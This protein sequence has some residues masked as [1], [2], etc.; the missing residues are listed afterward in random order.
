MVTIQYLHAAIQPR[1]VGS[2]SGGPAD[3]QEGGGPYLF[4]MRR[5][6]RTNDSRRASTLAGG[7]RPRETPDATGLLQSAVN[8]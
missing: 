7:A 1:R 8:F 3:L 6:R 2:L 4:Q 5:S